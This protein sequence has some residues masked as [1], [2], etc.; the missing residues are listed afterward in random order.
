ME[1]LLQRY[2]SKKNHKTILDGFQEKNL[3]MKFYDAHIHFFYNC[4]ADDLKR[5][6][7]DL[8][9]E[10]LCTPAYQKQA[11]WGARPYEG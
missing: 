11:R 5:V 6:F 10:I 7:R 4:P 2:Y 3:M 9:V 1:I 8:N